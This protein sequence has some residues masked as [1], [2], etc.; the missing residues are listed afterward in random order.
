MEMTETMETMVV[1]VTMV[2]K[3]EKR[4]TTRMKV[5]NLEKSCS[6]ETVG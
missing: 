3:E 1:M 2:V 5:V 4:Q 6:L